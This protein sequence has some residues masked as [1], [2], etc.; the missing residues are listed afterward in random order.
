M[1]FAFR[2][3]QLIYVPGEFLQ[4]FTVLLLLQLSIFPLL[5]SYSFSFTSAKSFFSRLQNHY[6]S[7]TTSFKWSACF[8]I[9]SPLITDVFLTSALYD[10]FSYFYFLSF[11]LSLDFFFPLTFL[12]WIALF[13]FFRQFPEWPHSQTFA[14]LSCFSSCLHYISGLFKNVFYSSLWPSCSLFF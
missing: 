10:T 9:F 5:Q 7:S 4:Q 13:L 1:F 3:K 2:P 8:F 12:L 6:A 11:R 14:L